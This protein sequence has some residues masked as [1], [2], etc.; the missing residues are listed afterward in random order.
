MLFRFRDVGVTIDSIIKSNTEVN[1]LKVKVP[2][3]SA[4]RLWIQNPISS[5]V[6]LSHRDIATADSF[7]SSFTAP[8]AMTDFIGPL[9]L[10]LCVVVTLLMHRHAYKNRSVSVQFG[11]FLSVSFTLVYTFVTLERYVTGFSAINDFCLSMARYGNQAVYPYQGIGITRLLGCSVQNQV[12]QQLYINLIAQSAALKIFNNE[13]SLIG[14]EQVDSIEEALEVIGFLQRLE[15]STGTIDQLGTALHKNTA[16]VQ[17]LLKINGC[18]PVKAWI[19][20][21]QTDVC[22]SGSQSALGGLL[23]LMLMAVLLIALVFLSFATY[24]AMNRKMIGEKVVIA[25]KNREQFDNKFAVG[26]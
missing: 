4:N 9:I 19:N 20:A 26:E 16:A 15:S 25:I 18:N 5:A 22:L 6:E 24:Q 14:R 7:I 10:S 1:G 2:G 3:D 12:F 11:V 23:L 8:Q 13:M 21:A 17:S